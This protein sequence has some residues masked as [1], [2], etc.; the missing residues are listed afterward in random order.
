MTKSFIDSNGRPLPIFWPLT[1]QAKAF[2]VAAAAIANAVGDE[3]R[4]VRVWATTDC[5][6]AVGITPVATT[7]D[8][9]V[10]A[11]VETYIPVNGGDKLSAIRITADGTLYVTELL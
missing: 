3:V 10:T 4:L 2:T 6:I 1:T 8:M 7:A 11:K 9:P 5:H